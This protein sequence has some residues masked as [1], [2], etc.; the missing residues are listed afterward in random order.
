[1]F[2]KDGDGQCTYV[3]ARWQEI[4]GLSLLQSLG[5]G[6]SQ[7][8]HP[9]D[10]DE[11]IA[12]WKQATARGSEFEM[13]FRVLRPDGQQRHVR[14]R[15]RPQRLSVGTTEGFVGALV[16]VTERHEAE[17]RL[18]ASEAF[19]DR[20]GRIARVGG[21]ELD[22]KQRS[23]I[24]SDETCR[25]HEVAPGHKPTLDEGIAF[26]AREAQPVV[27]AA[28]RRAAE[29]GAPFDLELP[30]ITARGRRIWV[31]TAGETEFD[32][33]KPSRVIGA[34]QDVTEW[35]ERQ[36]EL[37]PEQALRQQ[38][39]RRSDELKRLL[40][41]R[42]EMLDV[43][44]HEV[45]QPLNNASAA[46]QSA[47]QVLSGMSD[48][49]ASARLTRAQTVLSQVL[50]SIDNT[51]ATA[52]VLAGTE[53][54]SPQ[55]TDIDTLL[56]VAIADMPLPQ[57]ERIRVV[58]ATAKRTASMDM[59]LLRLAVRNLL[60]NALKYANPESLI[61]VRVSEREH[62]LALVIDVIDLGPGIEAEFVPQLFERGSRGRQARLKPGHGLGLHI[63]QRG[64]D[65]HGGSP[66][67]VANGPGGAT[68]RLMIPQS[69]SP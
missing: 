27:E 21:W 62:P 55:D 57:R 35:R 65:L 69:D 28:V 52:A 20:T 22:L 25:I 46:L 64:M 8:L 39:E 13:A 49:R 48:P 37:A 50:A 40:S 29:T 4:C 11:V 12:A 42:G 19:L 16:D 32:H 63:M 56:A 30:L 23:V 45:R 1:M 34:L 5:D 53:P 59:A 10:R 15:A 7:T 33:G 44:A 24:W 2:E 38:L 60:A 9:D 18:R 31:R 47:A 66:A 14:S 43:L 36:E 61:T 3:N 6:W 68:L 41:E 26:Y 51:L 54:I 17:Q 58:R 67:L